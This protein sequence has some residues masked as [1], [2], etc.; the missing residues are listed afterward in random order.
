MGHGVLLV[1]GRLG[2]APCP[3]EY[4]GQEQRIVAEAARA[5]FRECDAPLD[6]ARCA[7][8]LAVFVDK[9]ERAQKTRGALLRGNA[10]ELAQEL[11]VVGRIVAVDAR[12]ARGVHARRAAERI[13][14]KPRIVRQGR[15]ARA[16]MRLARLDARVAFE[17]IGILG[18][19]RADLFHL[20][21]VVRGYHDLLLHTRP[22]SHPPARC[23]RPDTPFERLSARRGPRVETAACR[24]AN[25][26]RFPAPRAAGPKARRCPLRPCRA[27][28]PGG[29]A[30]SPPALRCPAPPR[31]RP[32]RS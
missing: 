26:R 9:D 11:G 25:A 23:E 18:G 16:R 6:R 31:I 10:F 32:W 15:E 27:S 4:V 20:V 19:R 22:P 1:L 14:R 13:H 2:H 30:K 29:R 3:S 21:R 17:R 24:S 8:L 28:R 5:R 7:R 12:I